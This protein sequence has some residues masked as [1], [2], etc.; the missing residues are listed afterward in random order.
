MGY[1]KVTCATNRKEY[2]DNEGYHAPLLHGAFRL[3]NGRAASANGKLSG[4]H[5]RD[6]H[7][8]GSR[9]ANREEIQHEPA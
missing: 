9:A 3:P 8:Y 4:G 2:S 5:S 1:Q 6:A 7:R